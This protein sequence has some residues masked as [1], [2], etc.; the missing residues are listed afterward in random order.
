VEPKR[1]V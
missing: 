1:L